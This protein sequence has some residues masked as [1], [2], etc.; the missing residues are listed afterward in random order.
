MEEVSDYAYPML[1][2]QKCLK[3]AHGELLKQDDV[4]AAELLAVTMKWVAE[5]QMAILE[6]HG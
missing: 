6:K 4:R 2:A 1:M 5:A 3:L